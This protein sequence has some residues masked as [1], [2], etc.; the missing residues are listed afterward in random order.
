MSLVDKLMLLAAIATLGLGAAVS[1]IF[2]DFIAVGFGLGIFLGVVST[3][4][5]KKFYKEPE[6]ETNGKP[7]AKKKEIDPNSEA[8]VWERIKEREQKQKEVKRDE[9]ERTSDYVSPSSERVSAQNVS[10]KP[11]VDAGEVRKRAY[12]YAK[13]SP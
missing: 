10:W 11:P 9:G 3:L 12:K 4:G 6:E 13:Q 8:A 7:A 1:I 2:V 5:L